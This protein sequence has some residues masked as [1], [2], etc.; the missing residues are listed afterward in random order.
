[1]STLV[2]TF[3]VARAALRDT[4]FGRTVILMLQH[5]AEGAF[6]LVLNRPAKAEQLPF[7]VYVGGP[8]QLQGLLMLHG[9]ADWLGDGADHSGQLCPGVYLG[10]AASF[11]R[12]ADMPADASW[13]FR[14]FTGYSGWGPQQLE[15]EMAQGAWIVIPAT[16]EHLF[17]TPADDLWSR[18]APPTLPEPSLN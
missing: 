11:D 5:S 18:L 8:C 16:A 4:F 3:L 12:L 1:M 9:H 13:K 6:G 2:G 14:V 15:N 17:E 7:P 10:D